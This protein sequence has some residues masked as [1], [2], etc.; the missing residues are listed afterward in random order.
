MGSVFFLGYIPG[1]YVF[2]FLAD[3]FG[4]RPVLLLAIFG[5]TVCLI[6]FG[7]SLNFA[8][9]LTSR[10]ACGAFGG[11]LSVARTYNAEVCVQDE[12]VGFRYSGCGLFRNSV[13]LLVL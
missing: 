4:R 13:H 2:A 6:L 3:K 10:F 5:N 1:C 9:A 8:W 11:V 7:F 12:M